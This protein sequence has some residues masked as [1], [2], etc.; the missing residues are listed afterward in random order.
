MPAIC[1]KRA[2]KEFKLAK[3]VMTR[4]GVLIFL[5]IGKTAGTTL[6]EDV[7]TP[8]YEGRVISGDR[9]GVPKMP[10]EMAH[11]IDLM[12]GH[13]PYGYHRWL[14]EPHLYITMLRDPIERVVSHYYYLRGRILR[15]AKSDVIVARC[16]DNSLEDCLKNAGPEDDM[17]NAMTK[18]LSG[19]YSFRNYLG[20]FPGD[21]AQ[22]IS[23]ILAA[24]KGN[25]A[26]DCLFGFAEDVNEFAQ[27]IGSLLSLPHSKVR[28]WRKNKKRPRVKDLAKSTINAIKDANQ[29]DIELY[30]F[31]KELRYGK[32]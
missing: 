14:R 7:L 13:F 20:I 10:I 5:H 2:L 22:D 27:W 3:R 6:R 11:S 21:Y 12:F 19:A 25:L 32:T 30:R 18:M 31:A 15:G 4:G 28:H 9:R 29:L 26:N 17:S 23:D 16:K 8:G 1:Q 24:A